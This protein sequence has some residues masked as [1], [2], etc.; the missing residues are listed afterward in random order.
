ML[1]ENSSLNSLVPE[2]ENEASWCETAAKTEEGEETFLAT[3]PHV[4]SSQ[5]SEEITTPSRP[6]TPEAPRSPRN[7]LVTGHRSCQN[8]NPGAGPVLHPLPSSDGQHVNNSG[9]ESGHPAE[10]YDYTE[11]NGLLTELQKVFITTS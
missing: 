4:D 3:A 10:H 7:P 2:T 5:Q 6:S 9:E 8:I 1:P 11:N